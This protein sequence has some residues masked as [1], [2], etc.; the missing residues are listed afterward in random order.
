MET[1]EIEYENL[2][3]AT[4][5]VDAETAAQPI[6]EMV[7]FWSGWEERLKDNSGDY[8]NTWL[9]QLAIFILRNHCRPTDIKDEGWYS[10]DGR[11]GINLLFWHA[12]EPDESMISIEKL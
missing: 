1:Y 5:E 2:P 10:L 7:E 12:W 9:K 11:H 8:L 4:V 6:K 3:L